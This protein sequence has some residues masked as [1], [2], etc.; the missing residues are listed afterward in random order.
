MHIFDR[1]SEKI[2]LFEDL[3]KQVSKSTINMQKKTKK[4]TLSHARWCTENIQKHHQPQQT[5]FERSFFCVP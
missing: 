3:S 5:E 4:L 1:K 2:E